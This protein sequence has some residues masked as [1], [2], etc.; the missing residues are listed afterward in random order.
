VLQYILANYFCIDYVNRTV[1]GPQK[2]SGSRELG[3]RVKTFGHPWTS[4]KSIAPFTQP[5]DNIN[6]LIF[7]M[8][9][10]YAKC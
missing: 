10:I 8:M 5:V 2:W 9:S 3:P 1:S 7:R 6:V 4:I